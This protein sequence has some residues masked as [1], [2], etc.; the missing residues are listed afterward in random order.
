[1]ATP[2]DSVYK[3]LTT[4][5]SLNNYRGPEIKMTACKEDIFE[6]DGFDLATIRRDLESY[7]KGYYLLREFYSSEEVEDYRSACETF[8]H[9]GPVIYDRINT[10]TMHDYVHPRSHDSVERTFRIYQFLHNHK[11][12]LVASFIHKA[13]SLRDGIESIW[14]DD[15]VYLS[16]RNRLQDYVI[17]TYYKSDQGLLPR[18]KDYDG[19]APHPLIQFW[20]LLSDPCEDYQDGNLILHPRKA[21]SLHVER[22]FNL[23]PGDAIIFDK[24]LEHEV[25]KTTFSGENS[26]GRWTVLIGARAKRDSPFSAFYKRLRYSTVVQRSIDRVKLKT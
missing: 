10:D 22:D 24:S 8:L 21:P 9:E 6:K 19:P 4:T 2:S 11:T 23:K 26:K 5:V 15:P 13:L 16:E 18:H 3:Y 7:N 12:G 20:V 17:V 1:M 14:Y 25:E